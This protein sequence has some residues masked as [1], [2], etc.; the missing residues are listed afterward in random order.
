MCFIH[1]DSVISRRSFIEQFS[2]GAAAAAAVA[3]VGSRLAAASEGVAAPGVGE[4]DVVVPVSQNPPARGGLTTIDG[5][6]K[7]LHNRWNQ[8]IPAA[9]RVREGDTV[10]FLCRDALDIGTAAR[11]LRPDGVLTLDLGKVH[12]LTGRLRL[13][14]HRPGPRPVRRSPPR[15]PG[16]VQPV[17]RSLRAQRPESGKGAGRHSRGPAVQ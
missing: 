2:L 4:P 17:H 6:S 10:Q 1:S 13:R 9:A 16:A 15:Y 8:D 14:R 3:G 7:T 12:P 11:T 5:F